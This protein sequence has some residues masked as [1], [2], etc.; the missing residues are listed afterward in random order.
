MSVSLFESLAASVAEEYEARDYKLGWRLLTCPNANVETAKCALIT[1][2]PGGGKFEDPAPSVEAGSAY[3]VESWKGAEPG[4]QQLQRQVRRMFE[5]AG[6]R[7]ADVLSGYLVP[8]RSRAWKDLSKKS[9]ALAFGQSVWR[10]ILCASPA[11]TI[12]SFWK[13]VAQSVVAING[14]AK[15]DTTKAGWGDQTIDTYSLPQGRVLL[16][17]PHLSRFALF[18]RDPSEDAFASALARAR[19]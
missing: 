15:A 8:F 14:G 1:I 11:T 9:E 17:L 19:N 3:E 4:Q 12:L 18:H 16:S 10:E 2:N 5:L 13:E 6:E 7:P